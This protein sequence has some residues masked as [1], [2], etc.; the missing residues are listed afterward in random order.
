MRKESD[1]G[2]WNRQ[3]YVLQT[4]TSDARNTTHNLNETGSR[5]IGLCEQTTLQVYNDHLICFQS[6][7][8]YSFDDDVTWQHHRKPQYCEFTREVIAIRLHDNDL[9]SLELT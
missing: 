9:I 7:I 1:D 8:N 2:G 5:G 4:L 6:T 3:E